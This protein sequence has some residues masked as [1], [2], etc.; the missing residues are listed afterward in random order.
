[1]TV[2][3]YTINAIGIGLAL[4]FACCVIVLVKEMINK[5]VKC[6]PAKATPWTGS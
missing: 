1:M 6:N 3:L 4:F 2:L 5:K